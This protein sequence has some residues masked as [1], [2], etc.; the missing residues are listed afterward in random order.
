MITRLNDFTLGS[1]LHQDLWSQY[2]L[3]PEAISASPSIGWCI[4]TDWL[5]GNFLVLAGSRPLLTALK[6]NQAT[7]VLVTQPIQLAL[8]VFRHSSGPA[9]PWVVA[10]TPY[11]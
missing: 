6:A 8:P 2:F 9:Q 4:E 5:Q 3:E 10:S 7:A 1:D 11:P